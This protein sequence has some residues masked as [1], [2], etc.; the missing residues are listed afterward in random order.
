MSIIKKALESGGL[1]GV[2]LGWVFEQ[3]QTVAV[4]LTTLC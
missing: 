4:I 2:G 1:G 3:F